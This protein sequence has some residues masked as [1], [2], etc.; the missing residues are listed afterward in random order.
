MHTS[1]QHRPTLV[2]PPASG[3]RALLGEDGL[4]YLAALLGYILLLPP[5]LNITILGSVMPPYRFF[6]IP[7][8][9]LVLATG[10]RGRF[11][12]TIPDFL[13]LGTTFWISVSLFLNHEPTDALGSSVA[14]AT[15]IGLAYFF[16]RAVFRTLRDVRI[17]LL[18]MMPG[19]LIIGSIMAVESITHTNI[20]Q[21][22]FGNLTGQSV[23]WR[24]DERLGFMRARGPFPHPI[25]GGIF[26]AS[27][28]PLFW[29]SGLSR[30]PRSAGS[31]AAILS[32][33]TVSSAALLALTAAT[34]LMIYN[35]LTERFSNL[36]WRLFFGGAAILIFALEFGTKSGSFNLLMRFASLN[37]YSAFNRVHIW[38]FGTRNVAE[39]PWFGLGFND[40][41]RP[42][43]M[44]AS[45]DHFWLLQAVQFGIATPLFMA[46]ATILAVLAL[47]RG[48]RY[49]SGVDRHSLQGLAI[50]LSVFALGIVSVS[51]W[52]SAQ[53]WF[54]ALLGICVS[55][56]Y[57]YSARGR[58]HS[59]VPMSH[60][61]RSFDAARPS[62]Q[63]QP[64]PLNKE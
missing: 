2:L 37:S 22:F 35:W 57:G 43:W 64:N 14:L 10:L 46:L 32:F 27:F 55:M 42:V 52:L 50:A 13:I 45:I 59:R 23:G 47:M 1:Q 24:H 9:L 48:A 6:L 54:F 39:N 51:I 53:V 34:G 8:A 5:Q 63:G 3:R 44:K 29:M 26:L 7:A 17:F 20:I 18:L 41:E 60:P 30:I 28:L 12:F 25:L 58:I 31:L 16:A 21:P 61:D 33:F 4:I 56:G 15:D 36:T 40:W 62:Y 38:R 11:A 49:S 19:L